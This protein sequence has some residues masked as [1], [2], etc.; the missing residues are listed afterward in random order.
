MTDMKSLKKLKIRPMGMQGLGIFEEAL[1][2]AGTPAPHPPLTRRQKQSRTS[3][4]DENKQS[5]YFSSIPPSS[6]LSPRFVRRRYQTLLAK[7]PILTYTFNKA[8]EGLPVHG[9][10]VVS[11]PPVS[12]SEETR[13]QH[14]RWANANP[15]DLEWITSVEAKDTQNT[16]IKAKQG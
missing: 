10:Y 2:I 12:L 3:A 1:A 6:T 9:R 11:Q 7:I 14:T 5:P 13:Y 4:S 16:D 8:R 15:E